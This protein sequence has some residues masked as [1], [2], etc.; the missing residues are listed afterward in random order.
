MRHVLSN[1]ASEALAERVYRM[2]LRRS[3]ADIAKVL[4]RPVAELQHLVAPIVR[5]RSRTVDT[6]LG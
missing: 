5:G 1:E 2:R 6:L 4:G 3:W